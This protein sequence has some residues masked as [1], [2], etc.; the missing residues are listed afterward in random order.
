MLLKGSTTRIP[1]V[2]L[3]DALSGGSGD[4]WGATY[5]QRKCDIL[6]ARRH[7]PM[8]PLR[9]EQRAD[10]TL[11]R[12]YS[13]KHSVTGEICPRS[14]TIQSHQLNPYLSCA[15]SPLNRLGD[16]VTFSGWT[17]G[18][19]ARIAHF[20]RLSVLA[21]GAAIRTDRGHMDPAP[22]MTAYPLL[23]LWVLVS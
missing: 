8:C 15:F 9:P 11:G 13:I 6:A 14:P 3:S 2:P 4:P 1:V 22:C 18:P 10:Q 21:L 16:V 19:M 17:Y 5:Q 20:V 23:G 12:K 7:S